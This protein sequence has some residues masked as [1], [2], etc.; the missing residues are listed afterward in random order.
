M[1]SKISSLE[2][3]RLIFV[4]FSLYLMGDALYRWDGFRYYASFSEFI[5]GVALI[6]ILWSLVAACVAALMWLLFITIKKLFKLVGSEITVE[7][8]LVYII[9]LVLL[10]VILYIGKISILKNL[11]MSTQF[12]LLV[13]SCFAIVSALLTWMLREKS[14]KIIC[15]VRERITP[16]VWLFGLILVV[17]VP[18][19]G[20]H[21]LWKQN[22]KGISQGIVQS[23]A[24]DDRDKPNIILVTFDAMTSRDMSVYGYHLPT[25]PFITEWSKT[26]SLF[27]RA[28]AESNYTTPTIASLMTG[29]R[30]WTHQ[31]YY[32]EAASESVRNSSENMPL[33]LRN[34]G[35][36]N[37]AIV[38][39]DY[40][41]VDKLGISYSFEIAPNPVK[42]RYP[43][44][45]FGFINAFLYR[46][47]G[48]K[49]KLHDW[50][51]KEDFVFFRLINIVTRGFSKTMTPPEKAF[52]KLLEILDDNFPEPFFA[53]VHI[54]P[55]HDPYLPPEPYIGMFNSS[56]EL[57]TSKSQRQASGMNKVL[58]A[59]Y[60]EFIRYCDKQFEDFITQLEKRNLFDNSLIILSSDH[61]EL[62]EHNYKGHG[63]Q[64]LYEELIH[65][66]LII[67]E[68]AQT[69]AKVI[70]DVVE[71][72]DIPATILELAGVPTPSW[73][74]GRS[75]VPLM[76]GGKLPERPAFSMNLARNPG[77]GHEITKGIIAVWEDD[78]KLIHYLEREKSLLFNLKKDPYELNNLFDKEIETGRNLLGLI[79][80]N[81]D[82]ANDRIRNKKQKLN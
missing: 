70:N 22:Y 7:D 15:L 31:T 53:W 51:I 66:P 62:F 24:A 3:F 25:T 18:L 75:L 71:Q 68:P 40:A 61:G 58:R 56:Q 41:S 16:L 8:F 57:R 82:K 35:Y 59:R 38:T 78:Y 43:T 20:Y 47:F 27:T 65:I 81:L 29:K 17:S 26:A 76:R 28:E 50:I 42:F 77:R 46:T 21:T 69:E 37:V 79:R 9:I 64:L 80:D 23:S 44:N 60:D 72:I 5:P 36:S 19:V 2:I 45:L 1:K 55:P 12:K 67:K 11:Q 73:M 39:T 4:F 74:E 48:E 10:A 52:G 54:F 49:I 13:L 6:M 32:V 33:L 30:V 14:S 63:G 34:N